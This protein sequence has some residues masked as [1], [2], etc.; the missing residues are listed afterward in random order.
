MRFLVVCLFG[1]LF[2]DDLRVSASSHPQLEKWIELADSY[3][4]CNPD[5]AL[6]VVTDIERG[7]T[8]L[9]SKPEYGMLMLVKGNAYHS[10]GKG[11]EA[12]TA[13]NKAIAIAR[14]HRDTTTL[15]QALADCGVAYRV[16]QQPDSALT[17]YR[18]ALAL[19]EESG[20]TSGKASLLT[21]IAI[22]YTNRGRVAEAVPFARQA[23]AAA[24]ESG[25]MED[26]MYAGSQGALIL[27]KAG[28]RDEGLDVE[29]RI[30][31]MSK[32]KGLP[33]YML[34]AYVAIIDMHYNNNAIDSAL[35]YIE[36]G[37][38]SLDKVPENSVEAIGFLEESHIILS[39][40]GR[41]RESIEVQKRLLSIDD[42]SMYIPID[43]LWR[44]MAR[45]Y[46][47]LGDI[48]NMGDAYERS[49]SLTDSIRSGD[50]DAQLSEFNVKYET[51]QKELEISRLEAERS[52]AG[53]LLVIYVAIA[54]VVILS[55]IGYI[56]ARRRRVALELVKSQLQGVE[57][58]RA[59]LARDL[60][61]GVCNDLLGLGLMM[62]SSS[63]PQ[64]ECVEYLS[65]IRNEVR[66]ISHE[67]MPPKFCGLTLDDLLSDYTRKQGGFVSYRSKGIPSLPEDVSY[68]L[69]RMVQE[70]VSNIRK[71][72][73]ATSADMSAT[74][75]QGGGVEITITYRGEP[76][77]VET[78]ERGIGQLTLKRRAAIIN[79]MVSVEINE[80]VNIL[81]MR[82]I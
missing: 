51:S 44:S 66:G 62:Q 75:S 5:S 52:R 49:I 21:S 55:L 50:I 58:E 47:A 67:L 68:Q 24:E 69:Y 59:R 7:V 27:Y 4:N 22:L 16:A 74:F 80:G 81:K 72:T 15:V 12:I 56:L 70:S 45:N 31:A 61:D 43:H 63:T 78:R 71:H 38:M 39:A 60:H 8:G 46:K 25:D 13:F 42:A 30:V 20:E 40:T 23:I 29:R 19:I 10:L 2:L 35:A 17:R 82:V 65:E 76:L 48:D 57:Q 6:I 9:E 79:A 26:V 18:E 53:M 1:L 37:R 14:E 77:E 3:I 54:V 64:E 36:E 73:A 11:T 32:A 33:R 34:K 41:Y 28:E